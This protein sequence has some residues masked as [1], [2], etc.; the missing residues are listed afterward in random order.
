M[1]KLLGISGIAA[2]PAAIIQ[3]SFHREVWKKTAVL[4]DVAD[5]PS[6][7]RHIDSTGAVEQDIAVESDAAVLWFQQA[8]NHIDDT[9]LAGARRT[10]Q[11]RRRC[12]AGERHIQRKIAELLFRLNGLHR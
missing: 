3:I 12:V 4:K 7:C 6:P 9:G 1:I 2:D 11:C 8:G 5:A 10:E